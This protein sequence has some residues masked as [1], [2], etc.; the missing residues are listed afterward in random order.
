MPTEEE[1][2]AALREITDLKVEL[3]KARRNYMAVTEFMSRT[4]HE[5]RTPMNSIIGLARLGEEESYG[6]AV[7][8]YFR[9][10]RESAEY[11][12][13]ILGDIL[14]MARIES[15]SVTLYPEA[16]K[17]EDLAENISAII[18][19]LMQQKSID[20]RFELHDIFAD[21]LVVDK[22]RLRQII[23]NLLSNA[24]K[25]TPEKGRVDLIVSQM[26]AGYGKVRTIFVVK[27][28]GV[29][30]SKEFMEKMF[31]P[32]E[33]ERSSATAEI[34]GTGLGLPISKNLTELMGGSMRVKSELGVGTTFTVEIDCVPAGDAGFGEKS[35]V[36]G[37]YDFGGKRAL[38]AD[39]H[40][41]NRILEVKLL[42]RAGFE[43]EAVNNGFECLKKYIA[44]DQNYY[45]LILMDI[46]MPVMDGI[47][48]AE[49]IRE[50]NRTDAKNVKI[51]AM[52]ANAYPEDVQRSKEAGMDSHIAKPVIPAVLY[53]ELGKIFREASVSEK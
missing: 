33:Q 14:D 28:N 5:I 45:D 27:D 9:K 30:M 20:F 34:Q 31:T 52:S 22:L 23:V 18:T 10:I 4:S 43:T 25:F 26:A 6:R 16:Y 36:Q 3:S 24:A 15:G 32:F 7:G 12:L 46:K 41:I 13:E 35:T 8:E 29:G 44:S 1:Y 11:Q 49:K 53:A 2:H 21:T 42:K 37:D 47:E 19:P 51:V 39:D 48:A 50:L 38:I 17:L 40:S